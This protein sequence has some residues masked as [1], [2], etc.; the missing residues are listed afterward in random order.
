[1]RLHGGD[2][3]NEGRVEVFYGGLWGTISARKWDLTDA[4]VL[5]RQLGFK[6][7]HR[8]YNKRPN[9]KRVIW[10]TD[11][12][13]QGSEA[14]LGQCKHNL[15]AKAFLSDDEP[16][17]VFARCGEDMESKTGLSIVHN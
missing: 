6:K 5:C 7:A 10:F 14:T 12:E 15:L 11:F 1:M 4:M 9:G 16:L 2:L 17:D 3:S 13:C 8:T